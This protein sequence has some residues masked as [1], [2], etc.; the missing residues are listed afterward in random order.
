MATHTQGISFALS[1]VLTIFAFNVSAIDNTSDTNA[2]TRA[3]KQVV[4]KT[5]RSL[6]E[7]DPRTPGGNFLEAE[8]ERIYVFGSILNRPSI[9]VQFTM[10]G[11]NAEYLFLFVLDRKSNKTTHPLRI[12]GHGYRHIAIHHIES[13]E[14]YA[15]A[16][17]YGPY[18]ALPQPSIDGTVRFQLFRNETVEL[19]T[20]VNDDEPI[21]GCKTK[22]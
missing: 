9:A 14:I 6:R 11:G 10:E 3:E 19:S 20:I 21:H 18:D 1:A 5:I 17:F 22:P 16:M 13:S 8:G 4:E 12:G 2:L 7:Y 15:C